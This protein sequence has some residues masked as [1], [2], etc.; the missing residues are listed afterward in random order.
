LQRLAGGRSGVDL[1][2]QRRRFACPA[3]GHEAARDQSRSPRCAGRP[4]TFATIKS[5]EEMSRSDNQACE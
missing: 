3:S 2:E 5:T 1:A 4:P